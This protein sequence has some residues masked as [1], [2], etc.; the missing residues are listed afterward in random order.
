MTIK[1]GRCEAMTYE[2]DCKLAG[3]TFVNPAD[4]G[5]ESRQELLKKLV[6]AP[7]MVTLENVIHHNDETGLG[8]FAIKVRSDVTGKLIG[9]IPKAEISKWKNTGKMMLTVSC[10]KDTY[11]GSLNQLRKP[12]PK[13]Y[14]AMKS[15][16]A[17][18]IISK[19]PPYDRTVY[20][21]AF[22]RAYALNPQLRDKD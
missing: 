3:V 5:G 20:E 14:G 2:R 9:Y 8:E 16:V 18:G 13:Q 10:Y 17:K 19:M 7:T 12:T 22:D 4:E 6:G 21:W 11:S 15:L 1:K